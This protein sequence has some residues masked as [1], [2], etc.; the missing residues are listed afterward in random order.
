MGSFGG[1]AHEV[2]ELGEDL[3]DR[4]EIGAVR[5]QE[6]EPRADAADC[7]ANRR[8]LVAR[9]IVHDD[10]VARR[11]GRHEALLDVIGEGLSV[12]R[13]VEHARRIDPV[14]SQRGEEG[15]RAPVAIRN[16]GME[17]PPARCPAAQGS[18]VRLGPSLV[19]EDEALGI[20]AALILLPLRATPGDPRPQLFGGQHAFF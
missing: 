17:P 13:L 3:L 6:E 7:G 10:D 5:R 15:H 2:F 14:A 4:I 1:F 11:Q 8:F 19:D 9:Q 16:L 12:D 18:H 20:K